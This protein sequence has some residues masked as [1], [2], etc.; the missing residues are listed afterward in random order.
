MEVKLIVSDVI[1]D[2]S[3]WF[4]DRNIE[5]IRVE[6]SILPVRL[7]QLLCLENLYALVT[8]NEDMKVDTKYGKKTCWFWIG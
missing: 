4:I 3:L 8:N 7:L 6:K 2:K 5:S 1:D